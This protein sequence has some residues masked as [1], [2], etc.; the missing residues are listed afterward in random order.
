MPTRT[1]AVAGGTSPTLG[2]ALITALSTHADLSPLILSRKDTSK[3]QPHL[4]PS[5]VYSAPVVYV[6]YKSIPSLTETLRTHNVETLISVVKIPGPDWVTVQLNLLAAA[7][8]AGVRRFAPSEFELGPLADGKVDIL[9]LK[10]PVTEACL[11]AAS[12]KFEVARFNGGMFMNYLSLGW[13]ADS[14]QGQKG[15]GKTREDRK[16]E[17]T[18]GF[19]DEPMIFD[20]AKRKAELPIK[21]DGTYPTVSLTDIGDIGK[22]VAAACA[23]PLGEWELD[24]SFVGE[25]IGV[26]EVVR[27]LEKRLGKFEVT[28]VGEEE[29]KRRVQAVEGIGTTKE[30]VLSKMWSQIELCMLEGLEGAGVLKGV[31]NEKCPD[32][33]PQTVD[34]YLD[35]V[36]G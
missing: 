27:L 24:M 17:V 7:Q 34:A 21:G 14:D 4:Q 36:Y 8:E 6:D 12:E 10:A 31:V 13:V 35:M 19:V 9:G 26:D 29:L 3:P 18:R 5:T 30:S 33:K 25:V 16:W 32:F 1:I 22:F 11:K 23:L 20:P 2:R 15:T 28:N